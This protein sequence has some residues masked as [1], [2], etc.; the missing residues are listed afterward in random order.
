MLRRHSLLLLLLFVVYVAQAKYFK[1]TGKV[2]NDKLE[3]LALVSVQIK[4]SVKGTISKEDG[5]YELHL[6]EGTYD[7]AFSMLGYKTILINVVVAKDY[8]QNII[9]EEEAKDL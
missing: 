6:E 5:Y 4:G 3:P 7:L 9:M 8:V 1:I 2:T